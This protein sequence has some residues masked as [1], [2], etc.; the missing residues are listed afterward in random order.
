MRT[1][2]PYRPV[3]II[4]F[5]SSRSLIWHQV[6]LCIKTKRDSGEKLIF[7]A[8]MNRIRLKS[9]ALLL[10][11]RQATVSHNCLRA[12]SSTSSDSG[13]SKSSGTIEI[14]AYIKRGP[15]DILRAL[16]QTVG[17]DHTAAHFKYH[18]DPYL[19]PTSNSNKKIFALAAESG[20][21]AAKWIKQEHA[22]LFQVGIHSYSFSSRIN[23]L[24]LSALER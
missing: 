16:S 1:V 9:T 17:I 11:N 10:A 24:S 12:T 23:R 22:D 4:N 20:R 14:P 13:K 6:A 5:A 2:A 3:A 19:I 8:K 18:D 21:K 7:S 15:T